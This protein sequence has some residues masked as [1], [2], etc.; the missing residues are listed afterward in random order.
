MNLLKDQRELEPKSTDDIFEDSAS[1]DN[2]FNDSDDEMFDDVPQ[3]ETEPIVEPV[4]E[5]EEPETNV[6]QGIVES[7]SVEPEPVEPEAAPLEEVGFDSYG[8]SSEKKKSSLVKPLSIFAALI[9]IVVIAFAVIRPILNRSTLEDPVADSTET[10]QQ[11]Q[12][13]QSQPQEQAPERLTQQQPAGAVKGVRVI[14]NMM[15]TLLG[16][17]PSSS[18]LST[19][20]MDDGSFSIEVSGPRSDL[21][22]YQNDLK[23]DLSSAKISHGAISGGKTLISGTFP[24]A[25]N[26]SSAS[27][28]GKDKVLSDLTSL[29]GSTGVRVVEKSAKD[30]GAG[31]SA[32]SEI[33]LKVS[34]SVDQCQNVLKGFADKN[35]NVQISKVLLLPMNQQ[36]A[37]LVLRFLLL[38]N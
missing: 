11:E 20:F 2:V 29:S 36:R 22:K 4:A 31:G 9:G 21:E 10:T 16:S 17:I 23:R 12:V 3:Q 25:A 33:F 15:S 32:K 18:R 35:W 30:L 8:G 34:G 28:V 7:E 1:L 37:N 13:D 19:L 38:S 24:M 26:S 6:G 27:G 5:V 14:G